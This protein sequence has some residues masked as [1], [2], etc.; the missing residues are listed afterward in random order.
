MKRITLVVSIFWLLFLGCDNDSE[1][2]VYLTGT[3]RRDSYVTNNDRSI[4][5]ETNFTFNRNYLTFLNGIYKYDG[6]TLTFTIG[7]QKHIEY[8]TFDGNAIIISGGDAY[9]EYLNGRWVK[10]GEN[11]GG[12]SS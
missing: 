2:G 8:A 12:A 11:Q 3:Y 10:T 9:S 5:T 1:G 7:G 6:A 4:F